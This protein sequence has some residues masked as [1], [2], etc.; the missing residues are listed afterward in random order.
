LAI[1]VGGRG[2]E[3]RLVTNLAE[4]VRDRGPAVLALADAH[5]AA[6]DAIDVL[7]ALA[8]AV[9]VVATGAR[10]AEIAESAGRLFLA[11]PESA[12][13]RERE[14]ALQAAARHAEVV[15]GAEASRR[16]VARSRGDLERLRAVGL[17]LLAER[18]LGAVLALV[19]AE[20]RRLTQSGGGS[21]WL[22]ER[23]ESGAERLRCVALESDATGAAAP[24]VERLPVDASS[25]VGAAATSGRPLR[26]DD[27]RDLPA[28]T[29]Y[30]GD[31]ALGRRLGAAARSLVAVP[32]RDPSDALVG[33]LQ[34]SDKRISGAGEAPGYDADD[35]AALLA[36]AGHAAVSI[37]NARLHARVD[38][39]FDGFLTAAVSV[40]EQRDPVTSGHS[41]RVATLS[42]ALAEAVERAP[43]GRFGGERFPR[44][45]LRELRYAALLH[46]FG[47]VAVSEAVLGKAKKLPPVLEERVRGRFAAIRGSLVASFHERRADW[48][49]RRGADGFPELEKRLHD[50]LERER[51]RVDEMELAVLEANQ[52]CVLPREQ[53]EMLWEVATSRYVDADGGARPFLEAE[54]LRF[55]ALPMGSLDANERAHVES[56]VG[57]TLAFLRR[58]PWTDDLRGVPEIAGAHHEKLDGSGY[59]RGLRG[60][61]ITL[62]AR[63]L[64]LADMFDALVA[65]DRPYKSG[66]PPERALE[67]LE[68]EARGGKLDPALFALLVET[69]VW[70][71]IAPALR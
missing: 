21:V 45:R 57:H 69:G 68:A 30:A 64:T 1:D 59:P 3:A 35:V 67:V 29:P 18:D 15:W 66:L 7:R 26:V 43:S 55:V 47:K 22:L 58:I 46:D 44:T 17:S 25:L 38:A 48:L 31:P 65:G 41:L 19:I 16:R 61:S 70:R 50:E 39:L 28:D 33:V 54:E 62:P 49:R 13:A 24:P 71:R 51:R 63:I 52:P 53:K 10:A 6:P 14:R 23:D 5:A 27:V 37:T 11:L 2:P 4:A 42:G 40:I 32:L 20:A 9:V 8:P 34:L 60:E 36:L 12:S 56:H